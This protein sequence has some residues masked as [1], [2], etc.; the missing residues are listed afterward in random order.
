MST[1][2]ADSIHAISSRTE[3]AACDSWAAGGQG[4]TAGLFPTPSARR[5]PLRRQQAIVAMGRRVVAPP[6]ADILLHDAAALIAEV[7]DAE[8]YLIAELLPS[9]EGVKQTIVARTLEGETPSKAV[10]QTCDDAR[11]SLAGYVLQVAHP[12]IVREL[13]K[14]TRFQDAW[15]G[16]RGL[17]S[18]VAVPLK[19]PDRAFGVL[20]AGCKHVHCY[21]AEDIL[22]AE[23]IAHLVTAALA[24]VEAERALDSERQFAMNV[25]QTVGALVLVLDPQGRIR[26]INRAC[27]R[28]TGFTL[29]ELRGRLLWDALVAPG[30]IKVFEQILQRLQGGI[31]PVECEGLLLTKHA[32]QRNLAWCY[33]T[34]ANSQGDILSIIATGIDITAQRMA[35]ERAARAEE[36]A[37]RA[38][39]AVL[40]DRE[41]L[42]SKPSSGETPTNSS[43]SIRSTLSSAPEGGSGQERRRR[44]RRA[45]PYRQ[46][47]AP[48]VEG[49]TPL[50]GDFVEIECNDIAAG[51]FSY[52]ASQPPPSNTLVVAL[53]VAPK[54]TYLNAEVAHVTRVKQEDGR[55]MYLIGC[56]YTGR[57]Q[58]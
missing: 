35:E 14:E 20:A 7:L 44:P 11:G 8:M 37:A 29:A 39:R 43:S 50:A 34:L 38:R 9:K 32:H 19:L 48:V 23:T 28:V 2:N 13:S 25:L 36:A 6:N 30:D 1:S 21:E 57:T 4:E 52:L 40:D 49:R 45:Y 26:H 18:A 55:T 54:L 24:R 33:S 10:C 56:A 27:E 53:G 42:G 3:T 51:G 58:G 16:K 5:D 46:L 41:A 22:F 31:S 15:L 47:I 17:V 12:V